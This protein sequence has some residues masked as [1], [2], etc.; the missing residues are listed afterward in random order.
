MG[1]AIFGFI[2]LLILASNLFLSACG[3]P[4]PP[5]SNP[6]NPYSLEVVDVFS[7][8]Y[9]GIA[10]KYVET[11]DIGTIAIEGIKGFTTI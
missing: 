10:E 8:G 1:P 4:R 3:A 11:V 7:A 5:S 6:T 9:L 2:T